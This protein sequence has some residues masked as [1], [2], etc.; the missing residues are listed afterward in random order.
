MKPRFNKGFS[1]LEI[2]IGL[3]ISGV[4]A[5]SLV[6]VTSMTTL[7]IENLEKK[8]TL[9]RAYFTIL[10]D[11]RSRGFAPLPLPSSEQ[12]PNPNS[13]SAK[14]FLPYSIDSQIN[15]KSILY[16]VDTVLLPSAESKF[17]YDPGNLIKNK[18]TNPAKLNSFN[19]CIHL[20]ER[21]KAFDNFAIPNYV[22]KLSLIDTQNSDIL[23]DLL[24]G[25]GD[26]MVALGC[27]NR[28]SLIAANSKA[29]LALADNLKF[30][31]I[32]IKQKKLH[33]DRLNAEESISKSIL[34]IFALAILANNQDL[35]QYAAMAIGA[36]YQLSEIFTNLDHRSLPMVSLMLTSVSTLIITLN[37]VRGHTD[38]AK[39]YYLELINNTATKIIK[40]LLDSALADVYKQLIIDKYSAAVVEFENN[41]SEGILR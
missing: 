31:D 28:M 19:I 15:D 11:M 2:L 18:I 29:I 27:T 40:S 16:Q 23:K 25:P 14:G 7:T 1:L 24:I 20:L 36:G 38:I 10:G 4:L 22:I 39:N 37:T 8:E 34:D 41:Y 6:K 26:L 21:S 5:A 12:D 17:Y 35:A 33:Q 9:Q 30:A 13:I 32:N 3:A